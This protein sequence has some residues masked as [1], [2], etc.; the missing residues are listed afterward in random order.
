MLQKEDCARSKERSDMPANGASPLTPCNVN[1][2][3]WM[4]DTAILRTLEG[5]IIK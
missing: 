1:T 3:Q 4:M 5:G 2:V